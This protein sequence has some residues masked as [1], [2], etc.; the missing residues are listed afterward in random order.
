LNGLK[1]IND[2]QGHGAG[3]ALLRRAG[4]VLTKAVDAPASVA[5]IGG[6]EFC[7]LIPGGDERAAQLMLERVA[8]LVELNNQFYAGTTLSFAIGSAIAHGGEQLEAAVQQADQAM[9]ESKAR[10]YAEQGRERRRPG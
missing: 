7:I 1:M 10:Y 4:E 9:Y 6:D 5:R 8:S 3:D 2:E